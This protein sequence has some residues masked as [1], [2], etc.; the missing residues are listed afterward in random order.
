MSEDAYKVGAAI[1]W[2]IVFLGSW[3]YCVA[4]Y[5]FLIGVGLGWL[6]SAIVASIAAILWPV[7][8]GAIGLLFGWI[9]LAS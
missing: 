9:Y 6:P 5:G 3:A 2:V 7:I 8:V 1:S 4:E